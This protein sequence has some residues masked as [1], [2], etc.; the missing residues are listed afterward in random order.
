MRTFISLYTPMLPI[1]LVYML[2]Q[3]EY[4]PSKFLDWLERVIKKKHTIQS[5]KIRKSLVVT[6]KALLLIIASYL[7]AVAFI[8][9]SLSLVD[10]RL[11]VWF[12]GLHLMV[13]L[14]AAPFLVILTLSIFTLIA[15]KLI[16]NPK[17]RKAITAAK[18][19]LS[20]HKA[21]VIAV[22][23]SYGKTTM[24]ELLSTILSESMKVA[25]T[26]GNKNTAYSQ[27]RFIN[28]LSGDEE[29]IIVE[30]G[31][32]APGD[33]VEMGKF[34]NPDYAVLTGL[35][36]NH[37]DHYPSL[38]SVA[39]DLMSLK[40][41]SNC[42]VYA[43]G[44]SELLGPYLEEVE[45]FN[46]KKV[47]GWSISNPL[48][49][50]KSTSF[51]MK[52]G[53]KSMQISCGL[54]G[55]HQIAPVAFG[56]ALADKLGMKRGDI[57]KGCSN[58]APF[59]HRMQPRNLGGHWIIDDTYNGNI[60]GLVA[61]LRLLSELDFKRKWYVTPGLVDQG[62]ENENVHTKLG[63]AIATY[64]PDIV[65][66]MENSARPIIEKAM[67]EVG[68]IGDL[69]IESNPLEFYTSIEHHLAT[70]DIV[71]MQNDWT[72]NYN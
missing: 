53:K 68:Y 9:A 38:D 33:V 14:F 40:N 66:L 50:V 17:H 45:T 70:G 35:A 8:A 31:E 18:R 24:K 64:S 36:P 30:F 27:A 57:E 44:E 63:K 20:Q 47:M 43:T 25:A 29:V 51:T 5:V 4:E 7:T 41:L 12:Y 6:S 2:Q 46:S 3:V 32:G 34:I 16:V 48:I 1:Y 67:K 58:I 52:K 23:G 11:P 22:A 54:L 71:L 72:D 59:E 42:E 15:S 19:K 39:K 62:V 49:S 60:E 65:V 10:P 55:R 26:P 28:S 61:G 69:R 13:G 37:L 56:A 21:P